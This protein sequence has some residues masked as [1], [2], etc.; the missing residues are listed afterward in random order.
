MPNGNKSDWLFK[1]SCISLQVRVVSTI[2]MNVRVILVVMERYVEMALTNTSVN[3]L[4]DTQVWLLT[5]WT[6]VTISRIYKH[7]STNIVLTLHYKSVALWWVC[8]FC[9]YIMTGLHF[10]CPSHYIIIMT[11]A[12]IWMTNEVKLRFRIQ[13]LIKRIY[14]NLNLHTLCCE[15]DIWQLNKKYSSIKWC[16]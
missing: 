9:L 5:V 4:K 12:N 6:I 2:T 7:A 11:T 3:A 16:K 8:I 14:H 15:I 13:I 10:L 1:Y